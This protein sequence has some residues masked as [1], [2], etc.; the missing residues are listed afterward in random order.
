LLPKPSINQALL[1]LDDTRVSPR[2]MGNAYGKTA[3]ATLF[4]ESSYVDVH[5]AGGS[6]LRM[7][8]NHEDRSL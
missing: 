4:S 1:V 8:D 3:P 6:R 2:L 7:P 5:L